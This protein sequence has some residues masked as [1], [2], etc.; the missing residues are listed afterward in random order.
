MI[1]VRFKKSLGIFSI[2]C[3]LIMNLNVGFA[4]STQNK[5]YLKPML[6][7][8]S[9]TVS[10]FS[11]IS[12]TPIPTIIPIITP[13][14]TAATFSVYNAIDHGNDINDA[15]S[16]SD[17][18]SI[19]G[20]LSKSDLVDIFRYASLRDADITVQV[21]HDNA[22]FASIL[23]SN[24]N[25]IIFE[26]TTGD[27]GSTLKFHATEGNKYYIR[28]ES[29]NIDT[30][31][32]YT[33]EVISSIDDYSEDFE[34]ATEVFTGQTIVGNMV[35][36]GDQDCFKFRPDKTGIYFIYSNSNNFISNLF[37]ENGFWLGDCSKY[38]CLEENKTYY[39]RISINNDYYYNV[40][41]F[42]R[43]EINGPMVDDYG[44]TSEFSFNIQLDMKVSGNCNYYGD[45]DFFSFKPLASGTYYIKDIVTAQENGIPLPSPINLIKISYKNNY[46]YSDVR[47]SSDNNSFAYFY[48]SKDI[49]YYICVSDDNFY[50][51]LFNYSFTVQGPAID[52]I[53]NTIES[54]KGIQLNKQIC[55]NLNY[56]VDTDYLGFTPPVDGIYSIEDFTATYNG[57]NFNPPLAFV[58]T[59]IDSNNNYVKVNYDEN[60]KASFTLLKNKAYYICISNNN[61]TSFFNY[62]FPSLFDYTFT[63]HGPIIDDVGNTKDM[64]KEIQL[65]TQIQYCAD[66][67]GDV[68]FFI[69]K[70]KFSG[71]YYIE[72]FKSDNNNMSVSDDIVILDSNGNSQSVYYLNSRHYFSLCK[73]K[74]Y[75][76]SITNNN[77]SPA[78][79]NYSFLLK[80]PL[81]DDYGNTMESAKEIQLGDFVKGFAD[82]RDMDCFSFKP[83]VSD[84][85]YID[86]FSVDSIVYH[87]YI[88]NLLKVVDSN[89][90]Q[91]K[92]NFGTDNNRAYF[93][94]EKD[95]AYYLYITNYY[96]DSVF[97]YS[98]TLEKSA[99]DDFGNIK[100]YASEIR[101]NEEVKGNID[102]F[103]DND[104]FSF[105]PSATGIYYINNYNKTNLIGP[106]LSEDYTNLDSTVEIIDSKGNT[107]DVSYDDSIIKKDS[108]TISVTHDGIIRCIYF[109]LIK[110]NVYIIRLKNADN[111]STF[112]YSFILNGAISDDYAN[113]ASN[114]KKLELGKI[115]DGKID[116]P[117]DIDSFCFT[118]G[119]EGYYDLSVYGLYSEDMC[120]Y[121]ENGTQISKSSY[122]LDS[123]KSYYYLLSNRSYY[124]DLRKSFYFDITDYNIC[125]SGPFI[126]EKPDLI[127]DLG[128]NNAKINYASDIDEFKFIPTTS[129]TYYFKLRAETNISIAL[130]NK[131]YSTIDKN[132]ISSYL[133]ANNTYKVVVSSNG[134]LSTIGDYILTISNTQINT[135]KTYKITGYV[136]PNTTGKI[137][138]SLMAGFL[139]SLK[140]THF[141]TISDENGYFEISD[142]PKSASGYDVV[143]TKDYYLKREIKNITLNDNVMLST[144]DTPI[145]L[146]VGDLD[147]YQD[148]VINILDIL[149]V[150]KAFNSIKGES[151]YLENIDVNKDFVINMLDVIIVAKHFNAT[152]QNYDSI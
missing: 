103:C 30:Y 49:T 123:T 112:N 76:I 58:L 56:M 136:K 140:G 63:V 7:N 115:I 106:M 43:F 37:D 18:T 122:G 66:Y 134:D 62:N 57:T 44:N 141:S 95:T 121:D 91:V 2:L 72:D 28:V 77:S 59:V 4:S 35:N 16:I 55:G 81:F 75:Y 142:V 25:K 23:D 114:A 12:N 151:R 116:Y 8:S 36:A 89:G 109:P 67:Y 117:C 42:Y 61:C 74:L 70:P 126:D 52:D 14:P 51:R 85:Y 5:A 104:C 98:F 60:S 108:G 138:N 105:K 100:E 73:D 94:L 82:I 92:V 32:N 10:S 65:D 19:S 99:K 107:V 146:W 34:N 83:L 47:I 145:E 53:G 102:Y 119:A 97:D 127:A 130:K 24:G 150:A 87:N 20:S 9:E 15:F 143:I 33:I 133:D 54:S 110:D 78:A 68:D 124:V 38:I 22:A 139:I 113:K 152:S 3:V 149:Q 88:K 128:D 79:Y 86:N 46:S 27:I 93:I 131:S 64:A 84:I 26:R 111:S 48:L 148:G 41:S 21:F 132:T 39:F 96:N 71:S 118:T 120:L 129:G 17:S 11:Q 29:G 13:L 125:V 40:I 144:S 1:I 147:E 45:R 135:P 101:L 90:D 50:H 80:G 31:L 137:P 69:I 6:Q